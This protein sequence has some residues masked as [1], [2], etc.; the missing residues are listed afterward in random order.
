MTLT[1]SGTEDIYALTDS[2]VK[3]KDWTRDSAGTYSY[4]KG[5]VD[6]VTGATTGTRS[7]IALGM[8]SVEM[9]TGISEVEFS[10]AK[11]A[12]KVVSTLQGNNLQTAVLPDQV[13]WGGIL[14]DLVATDVITVLIENMTDTDNI[15]INYLN[16]FLIGM[17]D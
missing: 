16:T 8:A 2:I 12:T 1:G 6:S 5:P 9:I 10:F 13:I 15:T 3:A 14:V 17:P 11:N 7:F 4:D